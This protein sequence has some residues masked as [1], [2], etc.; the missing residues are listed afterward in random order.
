MDQ[1]HAG[2]FLVAGKH[3][4]HSQQGALQF[5]YRVCEA[6]AAGH[7]FLHHL[8]VEGI[9]QGQK[10]IGF[11]GEIQVKG[12][13]GAPGFFRNVANARLVVAV[14]TKH[15][16]RCCQQIAF[17]IPFLRRQN[18]PPMAQDTKYTDMLTQMG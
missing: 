18:V 12:A 14:A 2:Q 4:D 6:G 16:L 11:A 17:A 15:S 8:F 3:V 13:G 7:H 9:D 1:H 5:G 10:A